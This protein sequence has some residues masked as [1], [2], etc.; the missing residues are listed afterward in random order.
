MIELIMQGIGKIFGTIIGFLLMLIKAIFADLLWT[1]AKF[2]LTLLDFVQML[3][4]RLAGL[5]VD[6]SNAVAENDFGQG[7]IAFDLL[8]SD[9]VRNTIIAMAILALCL[10]FIATFIQIARVEFTEEGAKNSKTPIIAQA[11]KALAMFVIVPITCLVGVF[12]SNLV[13]RMVDTATKGGN[14]KTIAGM[15]FKVGAYDAN[16]IRN[17]LWIF[18]T[19]LLGTAAVAGGVANAAGGAGLAV[20]AGVALANWFIQLISY[21]KLEEAGIP[22]YAKQND[23][24]LDSNS[25]AIIGVSSITADELDDMFASD[26]PATIAKSLGGSLTNGTLIIPNVTKLN[27]TSTAAVR[28]FYDLMEYNFLM[29]FIAAPLAMKALFHACFGLIMRIY[30]VLILFVISPPVVALMPLD[31]GNAYKGW[32]QKFIGNVISAYGTVA[33]LNLFFQILPLVNE[34]KF[35]SEDG[36]IDGLVM[37][38]YNQMVRVLFVLVGCFMIQ[39]ISKMISGIIGAEDA[40]SSGEGMAKKVGEPV[41]KVASLAVMGGLAA[42]TGGMSLAGKIGGGVMKAVGAVSPEAAQK[43]LPKEQFARFQNNA[44]DK[45]RKAKGDKFDN[46]EEF[47][48]YFN[49]DEGK[50]EYDSFLRQE[51]Y[52][53]VEVSD[54]DV[55]RAKRALKK[56][57]VTV[58][59]DSK[60]AVRTA[61]NDIPDAGKRDEIIGGLKQKTLK[62]QMGADR[63]SEFMK[64]MAIQLIAGSA[65]GK[66]INE[67][68]GGMFKMFGGKGINQHDGAISAKSDIHEEIVTQFTKLQK[69]EKQEKQEIKL[70]SV[71]EAITA[72]NQQEVNKQL[73]TNNIRQAGEKALTD[74]SIR[75]DSI[76]N[77]IKGFIDALRDPNVDNSQAKKDFKTEMDEWGAGKMADGLIEQLF[78]G[79]ELKVGVKKL[80]DD[81][82]IKTVADI[83]GNVSCNIGR[84]EVKVDASNINEAI[85]TGM[86]KA[87]E[88]VL[89]IKI[90]DQGAANNDFIDKLTRNLSTQQQ[91]DSVG[92]KAARLNQEMMSKSSAEKGERG[93]IKQILQILK[94]RL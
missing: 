30:N 86:D 84:G 31:G 82:K 47:E 21:G 68:T 3:F 8:R 15:I 17:E 55:K 85:K 9:V 1:I 76:N 10:L 39:D 83:D 53:N 35:F 38:F 29:V 69:K 46:P 49:S 20:A 19:P 52:E 60:E 80:P 57:G 45:M 7:D 32:R 75:E 65:G 11:L 89:K 59:G 62:N 72:L 25:L 63:A 54:K 58:K 87:L 51:L 70:G 48:K 34:I 23:G 93:D 88:G 66:F 27:Y 18:P 50:K 92:K 94:N 2:F 90:D 43:I 78:N 74:V 36:D 67:S 77:I 44:K 12:L 16:I 73:F 13:L 61:F 91:K 41:K 71:Y 6:N 28:Y 22:A 5:P 24:V 79:D 81:S 26:N 4:R 42:A 40:M 56:A 14:S 33:G 37:G 64:N